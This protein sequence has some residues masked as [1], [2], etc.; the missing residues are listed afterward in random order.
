MSNLKFHFTELI[1]KSKSMSSWQQNIVE[2]YT[3]LFC[4]TWR[5]KSKLKFS[6]SLSSTNKYFSSCFCFIR[7][8][9]L[10]LFLLIYK[11]QMQFTHITK[12]LQSVD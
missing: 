5:F 6:Y 7:P 12:F 4:L 2:I 9:H 11:L 1:L 3:F 10:K 8:T